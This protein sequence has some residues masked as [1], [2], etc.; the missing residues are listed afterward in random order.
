M[1]K[2]FHDNIVLVKVL[3]KPDLFVIL[4]YN[5]NWSKII[6]ELEPGQSPPD[7]PDVVVR[8]FEL[9]LRA[10]ID[11]ITKKYVLRETIAFC[12]TIEFQKCSLLHAYILL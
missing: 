10:M 5:P 1:Q 11:E 4:M 12:Y 7:H 3:G 9:K 2:L 6:N 8:V